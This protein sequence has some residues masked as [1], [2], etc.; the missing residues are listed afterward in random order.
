MLDSPMLADQRDH[1]PR[2]HLVPLFRDASDLYPYFSFDPPMQSD[3]LNVGNL[4]N[5]LG[6]AV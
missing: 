3:T 5:A 6:V 4:R 1:F 2:I